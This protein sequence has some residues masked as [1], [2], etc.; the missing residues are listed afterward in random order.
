MATMD[1][2]PRGGKLSAAF[3]SLA[4]TSIACADGA[5]QF[6]MH[7]P[8]QSLAD[9]LRALALQTHMQIYYEQAQVS[10]RP[11]SELNGRYSV[12]D[13][14][15][16]LLADSDLGYELIDAKTIVIKPRASHRTAPA[17]KAVEPAPAEKTVVPES[18]HQVMRN[19][20]V[21]VLEEVLVTATRRVESLQDTPISVTAITAE[22]I[23]R[24][25]LASVSSV[26]ESTP[27]LNFSMGQSGGSSTVQAFI[28]G[29]GE[30]DYMI[31]TDPAVGLYLDGVYIA[32]TAGANFA[33][34]DVSQIEILRGPQ[35][36]L[37]GK[38]AIGGAISITTRKPEGQFLASLEASIGRYDLFGTRAYLQLPL[39]EDQL[40]MG[41]SLL[42]RKSDGWQRRPEGGNGGAEDKLAGRVTVRWLPAADFESLLSIDATH[43][44]Q[45]SYAN[46]ILAINP[47]AQTITGYQNAGLQPPCC[48]LNSNTRSGDTS[49]LARDDVQAYGL[50]W[51]N[52]WH[53]S[54]E[55]TIKSITGYRDTKAGFGQDYDHSAAAFYAFGDETKHLQFS[56]EFQFIGT[57]LNERLNW[58][59]GIYY[60]HE[61]GSDIS[62]LEV[63][64]GAV[65][66]HTYF[67]DFN[68][69]A[70]NKQK[71]TSRAVFADVHYELTDA[72]TVGLG[73]RYTREDK[74]FQKSGFRTVTGAPQFAPGA[75][76]PS[77]DC[78]RI[79]PANLGAPF[80]CDAQWGAFTPKADIAYRF[81]ENLMAYAQVSRGFRSGGFNG[82]PT[83]LSL[84]TS[85]DPEF[86]T[87][88]EAGFKAESFE[89][90]LRTNGAIYYSKYTDK[91]QTVNAADRN[92]G[93]VALT[94]N[95]A[96]AATIKGFEL[97]ATALPGAGFQIDAGLGFTDAYFTKWQDAVYGDYSNR[98]FP[99][100]P[101][102][103]G[104]LGVQYDFDIGRYGH[105][106]AR[107]DANYRDDVW[108]DAENHPLL[109]SEAFT[110]LNASLRWIAPG[111]HWELML[112]G[113][114]LTDRRALLSGFDSTSFYGMATGNYTA[115]RQWFFTVR[116]NTL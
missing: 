105:V 14:L 57:A 39:V 44:D 36:T 1:P 42:T 9:N 93:V 12:A 90:R 92:T 84:I 11:S 88:Y 112:S 64:P 80:H 107:L 2:R 113:K 58:V 66:A 46:T 79:G 76:P 49:P 24:L 89:H 51:T 77:P 18:P 6:E 43:Q 72:V 17:A 35:G 55:L 69:H 71:T 74:Y 91:Q 60:F 82:R 114:N 28:R 45:P 110:M 95:N 16:A 13:A 37:F 62:T 4:L 33:L 50:N 19:K 81:D 7:L 100:T 116:Y 22:Q 8:R 56:Q 104:N 85:Y 86:L 87:S 103:T 32:R 101:K 41:I 111:K 30:S 63:V 68:V 26:G 96:G 102:W 10:A 98:Q 38:N 59:G 99:N 65:A 53:A 23:D 61:N 67:A 48:T 109:R 3:L 5:A 54:D 31:T 21:S 106:A 25:Q 29:V 27:N 40:F 70:D 52:Q 15:S 108:L 20:P 75:L 73:A 47:Q 78:S 94:V 34:A 115:P 83:Q 97:E